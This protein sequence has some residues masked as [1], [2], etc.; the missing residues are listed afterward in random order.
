MNVA[1]V[2]LAAL[3]NALWCNAVCSA[4]GLPGEVRPT[5]W[6]NQH[7]PPPYHSNLVVISSLV[8]QQEVDEYVRQLSLCKLSPNWSIKD[9]FMTLNLT[10]HGF[11]V[12]FQASW[13][14]LDA[15]GF[16]PSKT[17]TILRTERLK[18]PSQLAHW[19]ECWRGDAENRSMTERTRQ[20]PDSLL[21]DNAIA[22]LACWDRDRIIAG[23][24]AN[25]TPGAVGLSNIF[26]SSNDQIPVWSS[27]VHQINSIFPGF[28]IVGYERDEGLVAASSVGFQ[29][30]GHLQV[31]IKRD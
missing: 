31:W 9:S 5:V 19:E 1:R 12:L 16:L 18:S 13:L 10:S 30:I 17:S 24:I 27:L 15:D 14:W 23:G 22:F 11:D 6:L 25:R 4:H 29:T 8:S 2:E 7:V 21:S 26:I 3:N 20:F 28:P